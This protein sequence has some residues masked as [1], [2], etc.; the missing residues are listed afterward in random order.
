MAAQ[1]E[2]L[3]QV[4]NKL[5]V[6]QTLVRDTD[7]AHAKN[8]LLLATVLALAF[9]LFAAWAITRQI[10]IPLNQTLKVA[11]RIA[12]GD[13]THNLVS[14]RQDEL[15]QLQRAIQSMTQ[16]LRELIGGISDGVT[17]IASAAEELSAVTEQT[18]AGV[19]S[20][21]V[22]TDQVATAMNEMTATV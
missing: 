7:V 1:G 5:T 13:L 21:K 19:N 15:G 3:L 20:Q 17:Q 2:I 16:G 10:V 12:A 8:M 14:I 11:E 9:G 18:S 22:E 4:S 6:S